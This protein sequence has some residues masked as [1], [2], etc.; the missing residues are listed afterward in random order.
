MSR[1]M[2]EVITVDTSS[3]SNQTITHHYVDVLITLS[4]RGFFIE[5]PAKIVRTIILSNE[6]DEAKI[7][8]TLEDA[9]KEVARLIEIQPNASYE[10]KEITS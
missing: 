1:F 10:I 9:K 2:I 3:L 6:V 5:K 8:S 4:R 7:F